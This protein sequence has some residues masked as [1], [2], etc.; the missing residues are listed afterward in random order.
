[1]VLVSRVSSLLFQAE[2]VEITRNLVHTFRTETRRAL[3]TLS[4]RDAAAQ[5]IRLLKDVN[6]SIDDFAKKLVDLRCDRLI[7]GDCH[8]FI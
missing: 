5:L 2:Q 1:M 3:A 6:T 4:L 7:P 8:Y